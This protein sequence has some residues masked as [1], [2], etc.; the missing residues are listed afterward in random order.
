MQ[1]FQPLQQDL[2]DPQIIN[3][4]WSHSHIGETSRSLDLTIIPGDL[5]FDDHLGRANRPTEDI[6]ATEEPS[7]EEESG[8]ELPWV[9]IDPEHPDWDCL[10]DGWEKVCCPQ[11]IPPITGTSSCVPCE[12]L[13]IAFSL[14]G[15][16]FETN[17]VPRK[18]NPSREECIRLA[19]IY[20]CY[21]EQEDVSCH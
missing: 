20:C 14:V 8:W 16:P 10:D 21:N 4:L 12:F 15:S 13:L 2:E 3:D 11:G 18:D 19:N 17:D 5:N 7:K 6:C 9:P 1:I